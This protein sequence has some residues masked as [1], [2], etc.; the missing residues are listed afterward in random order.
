MFRPD[1]TSPVQSSIL[2]YLEREIVHTKT[3][4]LLTF[5]GGSQVQQYHAIVNGDGKALCND[6][7]SE[8][9][10]WPGRRDAKPVWTMV[11]EAD[12]RAG[13]LGWRADSKS[14]PP[15]A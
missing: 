10:T 3:E 14:D 6:V 1:Q 13:E 11:V 8:E 2:R 5:E 7:T 9:A 4:Y 12:W 15:S